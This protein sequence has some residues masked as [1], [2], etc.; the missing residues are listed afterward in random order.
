MTT[1]NFVETPP[2]EPQPQTSSRFRWPA[3][4]YSSPP[5]GR[6]LPAWVPLGCGGLALL[7]LVI[8]FAGGAYLARGGFA[9]LL[10][11]TFGMT[12]GEMRGMYQPDVSAAQEQDLEREIKTMRENLRTERLS[13]TKIQPLLQTMERSTSDEKL[14]ANE[15]GQIIAAAQKVNASAKRK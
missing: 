9:Q 1:A 13:V 8:V 11:L 5:G 12:M 14:H 3:N 10:D 4:Y 15:V 6:M 2:S 7:I